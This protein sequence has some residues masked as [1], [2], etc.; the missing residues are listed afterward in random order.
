MGNLAHTSCH[1]RREGIMK[2]EMK[3]I[4][5]WRKTF[6]SFRKV[7][8]QEGEQDEKEGIGGKERKKEKNER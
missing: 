4:G 5:I 3:P 1:M 8:S 7:G 2:E 6:F